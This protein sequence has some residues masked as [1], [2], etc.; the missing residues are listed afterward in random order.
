[1]PQEISSPEKMYFPGEKITKK[2]LIDYYHLIYPLMGPLIEERAITLERYPSGIKKSG[3]LQKDCKT[4]PPSFLKLLKVKKKDGSF[5]NMHLCNNKDSL[6][7][8]VN[9][10]TITFH[11]TLNKKTSQK[12][13]RVIFDLDPSG[14]SFEPVREAAFFLKE[15]LEKKLSLKCFVMTTG[16]RGLH[17]IVPITPTLEFDKVRFFA[18]DVA[19]Y[20]SDLEPKKYTT[21]VRKNKRGKRVFIDYLRN[22]YSQTAVAPYSVRAYPKAPI[23][24]PISWKELKSPKLN[25]KFFILKDVKKALEKKQGK[26]TKMTP[27]RQSLSKS[28]KT[29]NQIKA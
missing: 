14:S 3:F 8:L 25:A 10:G 15:I 27:V 26:Y 12:P 28:I 29:L 16:S 5:I 13:D 4:K 7:Y 11:T 21:E 18:K 6:T 22:S 2:D 24:M 23:A 19:T 17:V 20:M 1:M 9:Q